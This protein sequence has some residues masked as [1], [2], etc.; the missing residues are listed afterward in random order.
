MEQRIASADQVGLT[1]SF[2]Q[3]VVRPPAYLGARE[4]RLQLIQTEARNRFGMLDGFI[5][6]MRAALDSVMHE[7]PAQTPVPQ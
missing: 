4:K 2:T 7:T 3:L 1:Q 5:K 6:P